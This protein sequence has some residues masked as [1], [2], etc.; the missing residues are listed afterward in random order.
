[1]LSDEVMAPSRLHVLLERRTIP[2]A[3]AQKG[4]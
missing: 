2:C 3:W 4:V 1:M